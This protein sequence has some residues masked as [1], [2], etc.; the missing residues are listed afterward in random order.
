MLQLNVK[1]NVF[2]IIKTTDAL[3]GWTEVRNVLHNNLPCRI[4]W[5]RGN[6]K[7][8]FAKNTYF[9][10]AKMFCR[11]VDIAVKDEV[12]YNGKIYEV[13]DVADVDNSDRYMSVDLKLIE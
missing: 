8:F 1:V 12:Q 3:G 9:R 5:K 10:D 11:V 6:E 13:V 7:L 2:R 4:N